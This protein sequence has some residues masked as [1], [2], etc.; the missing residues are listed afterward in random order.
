MP[1]IGS[2]KER[3]DNE[4]MDLASGFSAQYWLPGVQDAERLSFGA[5]RSWVEAGGP[6]KVSKS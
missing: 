2:E 5:L 3:K 1:V 6:G 4:E